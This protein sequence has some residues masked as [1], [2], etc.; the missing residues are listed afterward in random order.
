M[1]FSEIL[2]RFL[3]GGLRERLINRGWA[4]MGAK[5]SEHE[6]APGVLSGQTDQSLLT[7]IVNGLF[8]LTRLVT[9]LAREG[10]YIPTEQEFE[11]AL[12]WYVLHDLNKDLS[13]GLPVSMSEFDIPLE[14]YREAAEQ[15]GLASDEADIAAYRTASIHAGSGKV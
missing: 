4:T 1:Q 8:S 7:H 5:T 14:R 6:R 2:I 13:V 12:R 11:Q 15:L 10:L 3:D 9:Y